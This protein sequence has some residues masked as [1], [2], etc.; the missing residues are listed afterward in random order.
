MLN[1]KETYCHNI[2]AKYILNNSTSIKSLKVFENSY[3]NNIYIN[4]LIESKNLYTLLE[5]KSEISKITQSLDNKRVLTKKF[6]NIT[7]FSWRL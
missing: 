5:N 3:I 2:A 7:G 1:N 4:L 6:K